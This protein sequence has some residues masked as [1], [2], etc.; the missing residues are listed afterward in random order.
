M[1]DY[2][3]D[4]LAEAHENLDRALREYMVILAT[5]EGM[6]LVIQGRKLAQLSEILRLLNQ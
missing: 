2:D 1:N 4:R 3:F 6:D 5:M